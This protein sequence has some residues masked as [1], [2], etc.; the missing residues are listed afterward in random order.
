MTRALLVYFLCV[1]HNVSGAVLEVQNW[2]VPAENE[3]FPNMDAVVGDTLIFT[4]PEEMINDVFLHPSGTCEEDGAIKVGYE[5]GS[6]YTFKEEDAG[7]ELFF[8]CDLGR[9][10]EAGE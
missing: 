5:S 4:W 2:V 6:S 7:K 8:A 9:R 1:L 3:Y 10:C